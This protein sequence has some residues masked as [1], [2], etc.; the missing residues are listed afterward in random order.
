MGIKA[1]LL[2][3]GWCA[4][5]A[6]PPV[7]DKAQSAPDM[8]KI[9]RLQRQV[10]QLQE[11]L[12]SRTEQLQEQLKLMKGEMAQTRKRSAQAKALQGAYSADV[13]PAGAAKPPTANPPQPAP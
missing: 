12:K 13:A 10:E 5:S 9:D 7:L 4:G 8:D 11:Q 1:I 2:W 6:L 3:G